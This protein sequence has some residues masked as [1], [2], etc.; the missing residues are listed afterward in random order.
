MMFLHLQ[1]DNLRE[2]CKRYLDRKG[3]MDQKEDDP[4]KTDEDEENI[5][6]MDVNPSQTSGTRKQSSRPRNSLSAL[7]RKK[8]D[9]DKTLI[10]M[11]VAFKETLSYFKR[12]VLEWKSMGSVKSTTQKGKLVFTFTITSDLDVAVIQQKA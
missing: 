6:G 3:E 12:R 10:P 4:D 5:E 1:V 11:D 7:L 9:G 2:W 8:V